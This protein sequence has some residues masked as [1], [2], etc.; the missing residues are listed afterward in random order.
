MSRS[1]I[2]QIE[3]E[4]GVIIHQLIRGLFLFTHRVKEYPLIGPYFFDSKKRITNNNNRKRFLEGIYKFQIC[5]KTTLL[6][7]KSGA[8]G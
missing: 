2:L 7:R 6:I 5:T 1:P 4:R 3:P 8:E